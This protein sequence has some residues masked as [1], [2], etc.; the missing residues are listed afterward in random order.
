MRKLLL[1]LLLSFLSLSALAE[2][3]DEDKRWPMDKTNPNFSKCGQDIY[4]NSYYFWNFYTTTAIAS[5]FLY[6]CPMK[7]TEDFN[8]GLYKLKAVGGRMQIKDGL[9]N[10]YSKPVA[11]NMQFHVKKLINSQNDFCNNPQVLNAVGRWTDYADAA[12]NP[13]R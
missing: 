3:K 6:K 5:E 13:T 2:S 10:C 12:Y 1:S 9:L 8:V 7:S 11:E 4:E